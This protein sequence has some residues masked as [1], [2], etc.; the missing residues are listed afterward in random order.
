MGITF[1]CQ[2]TLEIF[3]TCKTYQAKLQ[4]VSIV[5]F[6][7]PHL[8]G[9]QSQSTQPLIAYGST[10]VLYILLM[11]AQYS[12]QT[13]DLPGKDYMHTNSSTIQYS[14]MQKV[15]VTVETTDRFEFSEEKKNRM[16]NEV[17]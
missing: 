11:A 3:L 2:A 9:I 14:K 1:S 7:L 8:T 13:K 17:S 15:D 5:R 4:F 10:S 12:K 16:Q 6:S